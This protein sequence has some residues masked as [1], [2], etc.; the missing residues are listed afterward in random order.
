MVFNVN[1]GELDV[2]LECAAHWDLRGDSLDV[3]LGEGGPGGGV[4]G[5]GVDLEGVG[6]ESGGEK[7]DEVWFGIVGRNL[8]GML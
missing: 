7:R 2:R 6:E 5:G 8:E 4:G 3:D 1:A